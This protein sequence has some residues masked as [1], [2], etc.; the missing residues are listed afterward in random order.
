MAKKLIEKLGNEVTVD[1]YE[2]KKNLSLSS[3]ENEAQTSTC[4][5]YG[6]IFK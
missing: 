3:N 6:S 2:N 1:N 5:S 4:C